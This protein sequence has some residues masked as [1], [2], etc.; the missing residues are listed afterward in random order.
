MPTVTTH[1]TGTFCW[2][3]LATSD[4]NA[5]KKFYAG[6]FGWEIKDQDMGPHGIYTIFTLKGQDVAAAFTLM[7]EM[8]KNGVPPNWGSYITVENTDQSI[9]K[10][11]SLGG[12]LLMGPQDVMDHGR[13]AVIQDPQGATF[14]VWQ[15]KA[16]SGIGI[17]NEPGSL[18]WTQLNARDTAAAKKFYPALLG[19]KMQ[20]DEM[21]GSGTYTT[22]LKADGMAGGMMAMPPGEKMPAHWLPYF[23]SADVDATAK[24]A[25]SLGAQTYVPPTDIP[26][27][28]RFAVLADPQGATFA[29][30]KF[31][32][33]K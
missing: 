8:T 12:T 6:L 21:P 32:P 7:P 18:A 14:S 1:V 9:E 11:K 30:I 22:F 28:G 16:T 2:P 20:D 19:W 25:G 26:G 23:A 31:L 24:K 3:E 10:A 29:L 4:Q 33:Q 13:M 5:A 15:S 17:L 27:V